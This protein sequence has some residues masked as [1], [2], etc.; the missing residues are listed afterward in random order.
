M[1]SD[2]RETMGAALKLLGYSM[3]STKP[4]QLEEAKQLLLEQKPLLRGY[5][6]SFAV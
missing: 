5:F 1:M 4:D 2:V 6:A 3:N